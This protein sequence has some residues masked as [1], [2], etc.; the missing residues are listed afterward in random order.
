[1]SVC[2]S[3]ISRSGSQAFTFADSTAAADGYAGA[4]CTYCASRRD[5]ALESVDLS[6]A[7]QPGRTTLAAR[8]GPPA[9]ASPRSRGRG[10]DRAAALGD[11]GPWNA[12][13]RCSERLDRQCPETAH[14]LGARLPDARLSST[15]DHPGGGRHTSR[16]AGAGVLSPTPGRSRRRRVYGAE[17]PLDV[18]GRDVR[19]TP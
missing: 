17:V 10:R 9:L 15:A 7:R 2:H 3:K 5:Q 12:G 11:G 14:R 16:L 6:A 4:L 1:M 13:R 8:D 19:G 18:G